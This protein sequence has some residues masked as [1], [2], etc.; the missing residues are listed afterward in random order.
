MELYFYATGKVIET[1]ILE[2]SELK[3]SISICIMADKLLKMAQI[4]NIDKSL[5][6]FLPIL[7]SNINFCLTEVIRALI[8]THSYYCYENK[9][10]TKYIS[11]IPP[12]FYF[13]CAV[14]YNI[15]KQEHEVQRKHN[16]LLKFKR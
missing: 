11:Q 4:S 3:L 13:F 2:H 12:P 5:P 10:C 8:R 6:S 9:I 7:F 15:N 14:I 16:F 1:N